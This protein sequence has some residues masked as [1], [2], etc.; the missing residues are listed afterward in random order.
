ME[1]GIIPKNVPIFCPSPSAGDISNLYLEEHR[2]RAQR[3]FRNEI[4]SEASLF[5]AYDSILPYD[6]LPRPCILITT[7]GMMDEAFSKLMLDKLLPDPSTGVFQVGYQDPGSP[8]GQL[9]QQTGTVVWEDKVIPVAA[10]VYSY[11]AFSAHG[12]LNDIL[13][14][15]KNQDKGKVKIYLVH[16]DSEALDAQLQKLTVGGFNSVKVARKAEKLIF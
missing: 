2:T 13:N 11:K 1:S 5:P 12:D 9:K 15:L 3:W 10:K 4:Y 16:G 14:F 6:D 8:G 7:S